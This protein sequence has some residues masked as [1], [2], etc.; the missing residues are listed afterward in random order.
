MQRRN[1]NS[2]IV[3]LRA[4]TDVS[5][6]DISDLLLV[7]YRHFVYSRP[8]KLPLTGSHSQPACNWTWCHIRNLT[9]VFYSDTTPNF[10][11]AIMN[12]NRELR[13]L[14][15]LNHTGRR[16]RRQTDSPAKLA[17]YEYVLVCPACPHPRK[18]LPSD[19]EYVS[20]EHRTLR[21]WG[22]GPSMLTSSGFD[23]VPTRR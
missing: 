22:R 1:A 8:G 16:R 18:N 12:T 7:S 21:I 2:E 11:L 10:A 14:Q 19:W 4:Q 20:V 9:I 15:L 23:C 6:C 13:Y 5:R 17:V 3:W